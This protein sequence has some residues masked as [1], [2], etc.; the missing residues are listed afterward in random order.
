MLHNEE[1]KE[2]K[3]LSELDRKSLGYSGNRDFT[4]SIGLNL[5]ISKVGIVMPHPSFLRR[6]LVHMWT[7]TFSKMD[8][9]M[10]ILC[11]EKHLLTKFNSYVY[12]DPFREE[13]QVSRKCFSDA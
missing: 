7:I 1:E 9:A 3:K 4:A 6:K 10:E 8:L 11:I 13:N 5:T 2:F 12:N